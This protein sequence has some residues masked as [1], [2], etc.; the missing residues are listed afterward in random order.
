MICRTDAWRSPHTERPRAASSSWRRARRAADGAASA[1][2][3]WATATQANVQPTGGAE[4]WAPQ[5][6]AVRR[7]ERAHCGWGWCGDCKAQVRPW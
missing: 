5:R 3:G 7:G 6:S 2:V 1:Q 4:H